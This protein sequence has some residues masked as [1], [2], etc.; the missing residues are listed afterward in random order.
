MNKKYFVNFLLKRNKIKVNILEDIESQYVPIFHKTFNYKY[1][2]FERLNKSLEE[3]QI[4]IK[5]ELLSSKFNKI[6]KEVFYS[7][8]V[9]DS[10]FD[11]INFV[12]LDTN[13]KLNNNI[14]DEHA[15]NEL[16]K[17]LK[18]KTSS[19]NYFVINQEVYLYELFSANNSKKYES[20]PLNK[21]GEE[22]KAYQGIFTSVKDSNLIK[23]IDSFASSGVN[24]NQVLLESQ[25]LLANVKKSDKY[26]LL[27]NFDW[28]NI[29]INGFL[30]AKNFY[31]KKIKFDVRK[32]T[33]Y[34][35]N[36]LNLSNHEIDLYCQSIVNSWE[37]CKSNNLDAVTKSIYTVLNQVFSQVCDEIQKIIN[38]ELNLPLDIIIYG[39]NSQ[40]LLTK[41]IDLNPNLSIDIFDNKE[42][43]ILNIDASSL[44]A[45]YIID[46]FS[47]KESLINTLNN[48][49][50]ITKKGNK[51]N[52]MINFVASKFSKFF[53]K[54]S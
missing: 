48:L 10:L 12:S 47:K 21:K 34:F 43:Q 42:S 49:P 51:V 30:N 50:D 36:N 28:N 7:L 54:N 27:V 41:M 38:D 40:C 2:D 11:D 8:I 17:L 14:V 45:T 22:L 35:Q 24:L 37:F 29:I 18:N 39:S 53:T 3:L 25:T 23:I 13:I 6:K 9:N 1:N 26:S 15:K 52:K 31:Y 20:F 4:Y 44:G 16:F 33:N 32:L 46:N 19:S 5:K